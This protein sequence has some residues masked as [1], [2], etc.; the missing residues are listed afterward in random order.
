LQLSLVSIA[1]AFAVGAG[2]ALP[3]FSVSAA[4][5]SGLTPG[6]AALVAAAGGGAA[7]LVRVTVGNHVDRR[8]PTPLTVA[9]AMLTAGAAGFAI[10]A[11][12]SQWEPRILPVVI[13]ASFATAWGWNGLLNL[14]VVQAY[15]AN[16]AIATG[17]TGV[18]GSVGGV[19]G[20]LVFGVI[21][22]HASYSAAWWSSAAGAIIGG[23]IY[24]VVGRRLSGESAIGRRIA[25]DAARQ[26][27]EG[28][29]G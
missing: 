9:A 3:V 21:A 20:P 15:P 16:A 18:G 8:S 23:G 10:L 25:P 6:V 1:T 26:A 2:S 13:V 29:C 5:A 24:L 28:G 4:V 27:P 19:A 14:A 12:A 7:V 22:A 11:G 17:I